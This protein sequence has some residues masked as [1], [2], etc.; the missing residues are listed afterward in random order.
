MH[1]F[2]GFRFHN[3]IPFAPG[4]SDFRCAAFQAIQRLPQRAVRHAIGV[5]VAAHGGAVHVGEADVADKE[6]PVL[7]IIF[8]AC[9]K[10]F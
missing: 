1:S 6:L 7:R 3:Q 2:G 4:L 9:V 8:F 5:W 10:R